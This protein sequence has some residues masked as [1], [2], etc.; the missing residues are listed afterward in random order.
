MTWL[1]IV[2]RQINLRGSVI[3]LRTLV[4]GGP[5]RETYVCMYGVNWHVG[6][7]ICSSNSTFIYML[8]TDLD[9]DILIMSVRYT[10]L[11]LIRASRD[12]IPVNYEIWR[13]P[14]AVELHC[15]L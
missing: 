10:R 7:T 6:R 5:P 8:T 3:C 14:L 11:T 1:A 13:K 2:M 12:A 4:Y 15:A 9:I